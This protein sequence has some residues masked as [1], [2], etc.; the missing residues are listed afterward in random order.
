[1]CFNEES[2]P[3]IAAGTAPIAESGLHELVSADGSPFAAFS[4]SPA[5]GS[6]VGVVV[7]PDIRGLYTFYQ[8]LVHRLAEHGTE[9][10]AIDY[11]GRTAGPQPRSA[12]FAPDEHLLSLTR[13]NLFADV[14]AAVDH[15]REVGCQQVITLGFCIGGH[16]AV[17][18]AAERADLAGAIG[19]YCWP[20]VGPDGGPG[21]TD[22]AAEI[23]APVLA[24]MAGDDPGIPPSDVR[25][26]QDALSA[27]NVE[28]EVVTYDGAP[29]GFFD[30]Q[31]DAFAQASADAWQ[32]V[33][34]FIDRARRQVPGR[35]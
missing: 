24:L 6:S 32:R 35:G 16:I 20:A 30:K 25:A 11:Y 27:A 34:L 18:A 12:D 10:V 15:L 2:R 33:Q 19:F 31:Q 5:G 3:P 28:H 29:H 7:L 26:L 21:P 8:E 23:K 17:C 14:A 1:M 22:R 9:A 13:A 4:A